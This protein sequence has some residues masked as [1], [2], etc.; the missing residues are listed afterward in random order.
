M[1][2]SIAI[3]GCGKVGTSL[4][5]YLAEAGYKLAGFASKS[6]LSARRAAG[7]IETD[8]FSD[9]PWEITKEADIIFLTTPDSAIEDTCANISSHSGFRKDAIVFHC[10]GVLPSTILSSSKD[11]GAFAGSMHPIQSFASTELTYNPFQGI[12]VSV[13]GDDRAVSAAKT[14]AA[15]LGAE[16]FTIK[17]EDKTLYHASA[18][19]ASNYLVTLL[20]MSFR[21]IETAGISG[22]DAFKVLKPLIES[23]LSNIEKV[24]ISKALTGPI[25]RGDIETVKKHL[26]EI[27]SKTPQLLDLYKTLGFHTIDI[28]MAG[29][30][31]S[32]SSAQKLKKIFSD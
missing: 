8:N 17:T 7:I 20:D 24:G 4:G 16:C 14:I 21:L 29:G 18:V 19:A 25:V 28:A 30:G 32:K 2:P 15:D 31:L 11:C 13:E 1:K 23:T 3:V 5:I 10:S 12:V 26:E 6:L 9:V 27:G 22:R